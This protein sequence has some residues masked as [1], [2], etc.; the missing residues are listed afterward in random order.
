MDRTPPA[1]STQPIPSHFVEEL[2]HGRQNFTP[3]RLIEPGPSPSQLDALMVAAAAAPDHGELTPWRFILIP[4][5]QRQALGDVFRAALLERDS[6]ATPQQ[7]LDASE[8]ARRAPCLL[9]AVVDLAPKDKPV[10]DVERMVSLGCATQ[11]M[12]L[13]ARAMGYGS[14]LSSGKALES[15]A[16]RRAFGLSEHERAAC[17]VSFGTVSTARPVRSNR[18]TPT[19]IMSVFGA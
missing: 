13:M 16:L 9:L 12:L 6:A 1:E 15:V 18:P 8:K 4:E 10:P 3:R 19:L 17:F 5:P 2:I 14:G 11:N 7:Q